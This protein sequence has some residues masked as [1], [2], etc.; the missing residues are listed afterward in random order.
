MQ[1]KVTLED[2]FAIESTLGDSAPS[3]Q[4][5]ARAAPSAARLPGHA[6]AADGRGRRRDDGRLAQR[7]RHPGYPWRETGGGYGAHRQRRAGRGS[8]EAP[9]SLR[10]AGRARDAGPADRR[11]RA[12]R[13]IKRLGF[14]GALVN[15]FSQTANP[16]PRSITI[17]RS[18]VRSGRWWSA[19][20]FHSICTRATRCRAAPRAT[21]ITPG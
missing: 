3:G 4:C 5:L 19:S 2:H 10:R 11:A 9:R 18:I 21:T 1:G 16:I 13:C 12:E 8:C 6:P 17:F 14:K 7:A 15:G 20:T